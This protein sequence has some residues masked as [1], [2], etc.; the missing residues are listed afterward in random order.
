MNERKIPKESSI[1][2]PLVVT[3]ALSKRD[4][5]LIKQYLE[6]CKPKVVLLLLITAVVGMH[7]A[8]PSWVSIDILLVGTLGIG[9]AACA[10]AVVN[11]IVDEKI[12]ILM[13]R[14]QGRP[15]PQG[16]I[17][18][19][20]A[21]LFA[22]VMATTSMLLLIVFINF[23]TAMLTLAGLVG[24]AFIYTMY[25]KHA[26]PQNIVIGGLSGA[27]PPLLG[28]TAVTNSIDREA[29]V[30][31]M[32]V[33]TWTP[34]HFWALAIDRVEEYRKAK[35]PMLPVTHGIEFTKSYVVFYTLLLFVVSLI[36]YFIKMSGLFYFVCAISLGAWF[37]FYSIKL[38]FFTQEKTA[39]QTFF[40]SIYYLF[41]LFAA[42]LIDHYINM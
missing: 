20:K 1:S 41:Y 25:L 31:V 15:I 3:P 39:I 9:L 29:I 5:A 28:W 27:I 30:L 38:K 11:H 13:L 12:D 17:D 23:L 2:S 21:I 33:F 35:V 4:I 10:A 34:A 42:L 14:T 18:P 16:K 22:V 36:P 26:T 7:L 40:V 8:S 6:L 19:Y 32:I 24:Y 37:V